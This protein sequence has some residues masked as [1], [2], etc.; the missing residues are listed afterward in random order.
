MNTGSDIF[1]AR[2]PKELTPCTVAGREGGNGIPNEANDPRI[3]RVGLYQ[4]AAQIGRRQTGRTF[5]I[6]CRY[7]AGFCKIEFTEPWFNG[8]R[9]AVLYTPQDADRWIDVVPFSISAAWEA[10]VQPAP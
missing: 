1:A 7:S 5:M 9:V 3:I 2:L 4:G 10:L 8:I 6:S